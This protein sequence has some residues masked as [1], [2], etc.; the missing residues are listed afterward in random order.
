MFVGQEGILELLGLTQSFLVVNALVGFVGLAPS[1]E[2]LRLGKRLALANK[3]S[4]VVAGH[5]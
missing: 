2:A 3:E 4:L 5:P 1:I